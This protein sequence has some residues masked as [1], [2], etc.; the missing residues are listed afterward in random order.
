VN[1]ANL[2][3]KLKMVAVTSCVSLCWCQCSW[4]IRLVDPTQVVKSLQSQLVPMYSLL[5]YFKCTYRQRRVSICHSRQRW[6]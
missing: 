6:V 4:N 5:T 1:V 2:A 3:I